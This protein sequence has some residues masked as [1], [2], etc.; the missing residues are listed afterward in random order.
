MPAA[1][2]K[3]MGGQGGVTGNEAYL[4]DKKGLV[5]TSC[6]KNINSELLYID[7]LEVVNPITDIISLLT[8]TLQND[9]KSLAIPSWLKHTGAGSLCITILECV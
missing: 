5:I 3:E 8:Y 4:S 2:C 1:N 7:I 9:D 6:L